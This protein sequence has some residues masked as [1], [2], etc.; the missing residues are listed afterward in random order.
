MDFG[1]FF[2][3]NSEG[4]PSQPPLTPVT[5]DQSLKDEKKRLLK[6]LILPAVAVVILLVAIGVAQ[7]DK[8]DSLIAR[9]LGRKTEVTSMDVVSLENSPEPIA[10]ATPTPS[11]AP[12][13]VPLRAKVDSPKA[14]LTVSGIVSA[15]NSHRSKNGLGALS[16]NSKLNQSAEI[17]AK[18]MLDKQYFAHDSPTGVGA[19]DLAKTVGYEYIVIA[20]NLALGNFENDTVLVQGW[21]DSPGHRAN[22]LNGQFTEIGVSVIKG[23]YEGYQTWMAVQHFGRPLS[24]C[25]APNSGLEQQINSNE[26]ALNQLY[27]ELETRKAELESLPPSDPTYEQK[28]NEYN[29]RVNDYNALLAE[30][31]ALI[32]KFNAKVNSFNQCISS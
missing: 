12:T 10:T 21:M 5:H 20:E 16:V 11:P 26:A 14:A 29:A 17:K 32:D 30:T 15:T 3:K 8:I 28:V 19:D 13:T 18:D 23:T 27:A 6:T 4:A 2:R 1:K 31:K 7:R 22:I 25:P 24:S 9:F